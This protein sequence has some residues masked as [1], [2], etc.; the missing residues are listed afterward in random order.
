MFVVGFFFATVSG[1]LVGFIG[2]TNNPISGLT[3]STLLI[4]ALLMVA[5]GFTGTTGVA[6]VLGVAAVVCVSS[7]VAGEL[8]QDFKVGYILGGTPRTIQ[9]VELIAVVVASALMFFPLWLL[10]E[11]DLRAGGQGFG[12]RTLAAPQAGLMAMLAQ[13]IVG[14]EMA[15][16]L[17]VCG[18]FFGV[19]MI[20]S[21]VRSP[22]L[23]SVGM[24]LPFQT[25]FAIF[26]GGIIRWIADS[27]AARRGFNEAQRARVENAGI[28]TAS[29]M[30]AGEALMGL[31]WSGMQF[32][33]AAT[34]EMF[35]FNNHVYWIG[36]LIIVGLAGVLIYMPMG[37]AGS[38][39]EPAPPAAMM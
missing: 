24:Y 29:G 18:M 36:A 10:N 14:G 39:D 22:M 16:P 20:M 32:L 6:V 21:Q 15:W 2:S 3:L 28:L 19:V 5:L 9:I 33:P 23:V 37:N 27:V 30:I 38:P 17:V 31:V 12:G 25:T 7:A 35:D 13:G 4:A 34:L 11:G 26:I 8:L 1:A